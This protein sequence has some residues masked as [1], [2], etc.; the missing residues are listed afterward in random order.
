MFFI[1][2]RKPTYLRDQI[3]ESEKW[4]S[5]PSLATIYWTF[6]NFSFFICKKGVIIEPMSDVVKV[7]WNDAW[8]IAMTSWTL[9]Q[10][11]MRYRQ[12]EGLQIRD[13]KTGV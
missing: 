6:Q 8:H 12:W 9:L 4:S 10:K 13:Q 1:I 3:L 2:I 7:K 5:N 11:I